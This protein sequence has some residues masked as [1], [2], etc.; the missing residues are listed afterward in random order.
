M[1][2]L[3]R[4]PIALAVLLYQSFFL[5]LAQIWANKLRALLTTIGIVIG[6]ASVTAVIAALTGLKKSVL[7]QF[8]SFGTNKVYILPDRPQR[9]AMRNA[10]RTM[11]WFRPELF[12]DL[13]AHC[14][15]LKSVTRVTTVSLPASYNDHLVESVD[16]SG[17]E[18]D[19]HK[20]ENRPIVM[21][22]PFSLMDNELGLPV[23]LINAKLR[24]LLVLP[25]DCLGQRIL[26]GDRRYMIVG[27]VEEKTESGNFRD[28][29]SGSQVYIPFST[30]W[31][32]GQNRAVPPF[33]FAIAATKSP[34]LSDEAQAEVNFFLRKR[35]KIEPGQPDTFRVQA[36]DQFV[37]QFNQVAAT[38][39]LVAT[40]I[41][42]ISLL[43][44]GVGIMNIMLVSVSERTREIGLR[45]AVG[46]RPSAVL[47]Q[48]L[49]EAVV[50][51]F[52]GGLIGVTI[53]QLLTLGIASIPAAQLKQSTVPGWA[54]ALAFG[55]AAAVGV[56]FGM[57]P[58]IKAARLDP[59][60]ALRHE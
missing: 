60:E 20:I 24:D 23:C 5:A 48:F 35:R 27:V 22:R 21:G 8:E 44:G 51:C 53:G 9:G 50:L 13:L 17:I 6:V 52:M 2:G 16:V 4:A 26:I 46:A 45:K 41:V 15:S 12:D 49:V 10:P 39:T 11:I 58:A 33:V 42:G 37:R 55:F 43:V 38:I 19:W 40:G 3:L 28:G 1:T 29:V 54:I 36:V 14:P 7:T 47:L 31:R 30:A 56:I 25:R 59:I 32:G 18:P 34:D 57:F